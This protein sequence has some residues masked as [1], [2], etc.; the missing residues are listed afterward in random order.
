MNPEVAP[1]RLSEKQT[2]EGY[3]TAVQEHQPSHSVIVGSTSRQPDRS[4]LLTAVVGPWVL[5]RR[6]R[7][8]HEG[9]VETTSQISRTC[10]NK[11]WSRF[12]ADHRLPSLLP[13][14]ALAIQQSHCEEEPVPFPQRSGVQKLLGG[15]SQ[16]QRKT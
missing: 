3:I 14:E 6:G 5:G 12:R 16:S 13:L 8:G 1:P 4:R 9:V 10:L 7:N 2:P 11:R 15:M